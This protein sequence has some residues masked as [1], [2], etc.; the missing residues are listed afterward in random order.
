MSDNSYCE[1]DIYIQKYK[2]N[3]ETIKFVNGT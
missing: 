1:D 3:N 2:I